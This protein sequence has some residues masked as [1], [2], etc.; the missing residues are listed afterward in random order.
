MLPI[1]LQGRKYFDIVDVQSTPPGSGSQTFRTVWVRNVG[2]VR[3]F[4]TDGT[5]W[6]LVRYHINQ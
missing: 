6:N 1:E 5:I 2:I 3:R 4:M